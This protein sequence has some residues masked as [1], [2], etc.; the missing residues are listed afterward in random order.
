[1][2]FAKMLVDLAARDID[3]ELYKKVCEAFAA[4]L[5]HT[6]RNSA[7]LFSYVVKSLDKLPSAY[8][9]IVSK[10]ALASLIQSLGEE[11]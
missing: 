2:R 3:Q 1:M 10:T 7:R 4:C 9:S 8:Q 6:E 11:L 5:L